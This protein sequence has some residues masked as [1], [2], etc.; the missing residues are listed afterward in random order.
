[1]KRINYLWFRLF[2]VASA[3]AFVSACGGG[4]GGTSTTGT[5]TSV[6]KV[7]SKIS[8]VEPKASKTA[9]KVSLL[10]RSSA[11]SRS[12]SA[13]RDADF[14][15]SSD[16][17]KD[18]TFF[19]VQDETSESLNTVNSLLC[20]FDKVN[21][22]DMAG[23]GNYKALIDIEQCDQEVGSASGASAGGDD[24]NSGGSRPDLTTWIV[25]S[26]EQGTDQLVVKIWVEDEAGNDGP[27]GG[28]GTDGTL[29][30]GPMMDTQNA[31]I[32]AKMI[33]NRAAEGDDH[34]F[35][36]NFAFY[37]VD[38]AGNMAETAETKGYMKKTVGA[39]GGEKQIQFYSVSQ[40]FE[41]V[42]EEGL[43][44]SYN[45]TTQ[46]GSGSTLGMEWGMAGP[47]AVKNNFAYNT[48]YFHRE[49]I[50][51]ERACMDRNNFHETAWRYGMYDSA[52]GE[53]VEINSGFP[54]SK[55]VAG[56]TYYGW[57]GMWGLWMPE[58]AGI[59]EGVQVTKDSYSDEVGE[60]YT[61]TQRGGKLERHSK[62]TLTMDEVKNIPLNWWDQVSS[63]EFQ[64]MW[65][66]SKL[67][68]IADRG[69][70]SWRWQP[71]E[72]AVEVLFSAGTY[73][74]YFYAQSLGGAGQIKFA[75]IID[76]EADV[77]VVNAD[78]SVIF[79]SQETVFLNDPAVPTSL[80][81][82]DDC[83]N[84]LNLDQSD[85]H[86][87]RHYDDVG[88]PIEYTFSDGVLTEVG[89]NDVILATATT[90]N[91]GVW[92]GAL[93]ENTI[94]NLDKLKCDWDAAKTCAWKAWDQLDVFY[95]WQTGPNE[96]N[97]MTSLKDGSGN[98]QKFDL[99]KQVKYTHQTGKYKDSV[100]YLDYEGFG[101]LWGIPETCMNK[102]T[103]IT[104]DCWDVTH[105][106]WESN[107][108]RWMSQ[109]V[110][111]ATVDGIRSV[112]IG[113]DAASTE[114]VIKALD[115]EQSPRKVDDAFCSVSELALETQT[116][117][118]LEGWVAP[119]LGAMPEVSGAPAVIN[120]VVQSGAVQARK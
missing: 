115:V 61:V 34:P 93:F 49:N 109:F 40:E 68:K 111:P 20:Q 81:C 1:M 22:L 76:D 43:T 44:L 14:L 85:P 78:S 35:E 12:A 28:G 119:G 50:A 114:Y 107:S 29:A 4:G 47:T 105:E 18:E 87:P 77:P 106:E 25:N 95:T 63:S 92:N 103:G 64:V 54:I 65:D 91:S 80:V 89:A 19:Y 74:F 75:N 98:I 108:I 66:G 48:D 69:P 31:I 46:R 5:G 88:A 100:F 72:P 39:V 60:T 53:R 8:I 101:N 116:L 104:K 10:S 3:L 86:H 83:L 67:V 110:I 99:P 13:S 16:Y 62:K 117:P 24:N 70:P 51:Q 27:Q 102:D 26:E 17:E 90:N 82:Y 7:D 42:W 58:E 59:S 36:M 113:S 73:G 55:T 118:T 23:L 120:G 15:S 112:A 37:P 52:T 9:S 45:T 84:S 94:A 96:W 2:L 56:E 41:E 33:I 79:H 11:E 30:G 57:V 97:K 38:D 71:I 32:Q 21:A 6:L